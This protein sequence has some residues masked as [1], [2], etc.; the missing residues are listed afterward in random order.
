MFS[1][2]LF[3]G[4]KSQ[5]KGNERNTNLNRVS[6]SLIKK[7]NS[8]LLPSAKP[9]VNPFKHLSFTKVINGNYLYHTKNDLK[10]DPDNFM[11]IYIQISKLNEESLVLS[12]ISELIWQDSFKKQLEILEKA[13]YFDFSVQILGD[14]IYFVFSIQTHYDLK[15]AEK[16]FNSLL[17]NSRITIESLSKEDFESYRSKLQTH[18][19]KL[20]SLRT[21]EERSDFA[22]GRA[23]FG[24]PEF[25]YFFDL[26]ERALTFT[27]EKITKSDIN[28]FFSD[29]VKF[30]SHRMT[31]AIDSQRY[32]STYG[33]EIYKGVKNTNGV[34]EIKGLKSPF[35]N[36]VV[37]NSLNKVISDN[38]GTEEVPYT[39]EYDKEFKDFDKDSGKT[40]EVRDKYFLSENKYSGLD[41]RKKNYMRK[42]N[43]NGISQ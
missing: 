11:Q 14:V 24:E 6:S 40:A 1:L 3:L 8:I 31:I 9:N 27:K 42:R 29:V 26:G 22:W 35:N 7:R 17:E 20:F 23:V 15:A 25:D 36:G 13:N 33:Q 21:L 28:F 32:Q 2:I 12:K 37:Q 16:S 18:L 43:P 4:N 41:Q 34:Y 5:K 39:E 10:E 30:N 38:H 19:E